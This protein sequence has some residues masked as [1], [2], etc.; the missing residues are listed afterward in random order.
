M[1]KKIELADDLK[2]E[3]ISQ[4]RIY[5]RNILNSTDLN[6]HVSEGECL[7]LRRLYEAYCDKTAWPI[8]SPPKSFFPKHEKGNGFTTKCFGIEFEDGTHGIFSIDK[9]LT[10]VA[11]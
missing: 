1:V 10:A 9:A 11:T 3:S 2:F 6:H 8:E 7:S 5:F 4:A